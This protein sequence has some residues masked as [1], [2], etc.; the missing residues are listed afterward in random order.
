M[1][2]ANVFMPNTGT[3]IRESKK[4]PLTCINEEKIIQS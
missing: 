1:Q 3:V 2:A 4:K